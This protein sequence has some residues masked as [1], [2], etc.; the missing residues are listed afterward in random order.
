MTLVRSHRSNIV[1]TVSSS[2]R[3]SPSRWTDRSVSFS[4][5]SLERTTED[6]PCERGRTGRRGV[7]LWGVQGLPFAAVREGRKISLKRRREVGEEEIIH[8]GNQK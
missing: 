2:L 3:A 7:I 5:S 6:D 1:E 4:V 8:L